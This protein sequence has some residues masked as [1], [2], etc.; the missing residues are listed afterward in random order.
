MVNKVEKSKSILICH[1][2]SFKKLLFKQKFDLN[3]GSHFLNPEPGKEGT[4]TAAKLPHFPEFLG[5]SEKTFGLSAQRSETRNCSFL[6]ETFPRLLPAK[7]GFA[8][9][10]MDFF[11]PR[12]F[13]LYLISRLFKKY[14]TVSPRP[15]NFSVASGGRNSMSPTQTPLNVTN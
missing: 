4:F 11:Q 12:I 6:A 9:Q 14:C 15:L 7:A 8:C 2:N 1:V 5:R 13:Q 10:K 3:N